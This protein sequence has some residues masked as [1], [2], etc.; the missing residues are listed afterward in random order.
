M[1]F[2]ASA[3]RPWVL[4]TET[5][6]R[7]NLAL[8]LGLSCVS[9][10]EPSPYEFFFILL[11]PVAL[12][13]GVAVTRTTITLFFLVFAIVVSQIVSLLPYL[14]ERAGDEGLTPTMYTVYTL[15]LYATAILFALIFSRRTAERLTL[16]LKAYAF[17][18]VFA[19]VWGILSY[20]DV[21]GIGEREPI[22]GRVA[23]PFKDPNVLGSYCV[24]GALYLL[25]CCLIGRAR[26]RPVALAGL[27]ITLFGG[28]FLSFSRG[29]WG[30]MIAAAVMMGL[31]TFATTRDRA[32]RRRLLLGVAGLAVALMVGGAT[33][34]SNAT[35]RETL[36]QR[37]QLEQEYDG[38]VTGRF[39]NQKRAIPMLMERPWGLGPYRFPFTFYLQP[40]N[41][42]IGAFSDAG[43]TG[44]VA[45]LL[46]VVLSSVMA[47]RLTL[48]RS[49]FLR[50]AQVVS[51]ALLGFFLQAL[52]ID[53]DHW[54]FV[55]LMLGAVWGMESARRAAMVAPIRVHANEPSPLLDDGM[56]RG[57]SD[58]APHA[59]RP[60]G[61]H[62]R[63]FE[64]DV[65]G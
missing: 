1:T 17:S 13:N 26:Y 8:M 50:Q 18:C 31:T 36:T 53:I 24:M 51:P 23:G 65:E 57:G 22:L 38:G 30:A 43:W 46:L 58:P 34:L 47:V 44:G 64:H 35:L 59:Q 6:L 39:G 25:Q 2:A 32:M 19:G 33:V 29:S 10:I 45:F 15:Y 42:Y 37:A 54:R 48:V 9:F 49:P 20:L 14:A 28:V 41:S 63:A 62:E 5:L 27:L 40:H 12:L 61:A 3:T 11:I 55:F 21:A 52:Q 7:G 4:K 16:C 60:V 56:R